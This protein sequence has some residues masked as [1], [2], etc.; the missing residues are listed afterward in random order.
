MSI[1]TYKIKYQIRLTLIIY[2]YSKVNDL[3]FNL[4]L[5]K[6]SAHTYSREMLKHRQTQILTQILIQ[7]Q[8]YTYTQILTHKHSHTNTHTQ[9]LTHKH[10]H[11]YIRTH[12][13]MR[14]R[15]LVPTEFE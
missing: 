3:L 8:T 12:I 1:K 5:Y 4:M 14:Q 11:T 9:T 10:T 13:R 6:G 15:R 7:T 2:N